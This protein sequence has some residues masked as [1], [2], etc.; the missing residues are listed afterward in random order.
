MILSV[1]AMV[2]LGLDLVFKRRGIKLIGYTAFGGIVLSAL[3]T[4]PL[5]TRNDV[6]FGGALVVDPMAVFFKFIFLAAAALVVL[7]SIDFVER[8]DLPGGEY[9]GLLLFAT[10]GLMFMASTRELITIFV[11]LELASIALYVLA[12]LVRQDAKSAEAAIKYM[13]LGAI[14]SAVVLYG[15]ALLYGLTGTTVLG[16]IGT[17]LTAGGSSP[18]LTMAVVFVIAGFGFKIA[19]VPF[20]MWAPDV[21]EGA[22]TPVTAFLSVG[23]KAAGFAILMRML[24]SALAPTTDIWPGLFAI[25]A[26]LTMTVGNLSALRQSNIKRMLAYSSIAQAGYAMMGLAALAGTN[27][28]EA[29]PASGIMVF[30]LAYLATNLGAFIAIIAFFTQSG[31]DNIADYAGLAKRSPLL[32]LA[33]TVCLISLGGMPPMVGFISKFYLF[34]G[35]FQQGLQW[36]VIIGVLNSA[37]SLYYYLRVV[38]AMYFGQPQAEERITT[39]APV[40]VAMAASIIAVFIL[41][42]YPSPFM[43]LATNAATALFH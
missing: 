17:A 21:Y 27:S 40:R 34:A 5:L 14:S 36:L 41:G 29:S 10:V 19:S 28:G 7:A 33:L 3:A 6:S 15:M 4:I 18:A 8:Q 24:T 42:L 31:S 11:S 43:T 32:A 9:F 38:K 12:G 16:E 37:I 2:V 39:T 22:P 13:L 20:H 25:L 23:S 30:L 35:V 26:T 1:M